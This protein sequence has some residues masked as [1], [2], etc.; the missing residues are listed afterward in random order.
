MYTHAS[1]SC[2]LQCLNCLHSCDN[3]R[4]WSRQII[5]AEVKALKWSHIWPTVRDCARNGIIFKVSIYKSKIWVI[6]VYNWD[7]I[8]ITCLSSWLICSTHQEEVQTRNWHQSF[9]RKSISIS[10]FSVS[11]WTYIDCKLANWVKVDGIGP[12]ILLKLKSLY[13]IWIRL[14]FPIEYLIVCTCFEDQVFYQTHRVIVHWDCCER[15]LW[16]K[17]K[18]Y[19]K[20][21]E[22]E[23]IVLHL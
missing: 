14:C 12:E 7:W 8:Y 15:D 22:R 13:K 18:G 6:S 10:S 4:E 23:K 1:Y 5:I 17:K 3:I 20:F 19:F 16:R 11:I 2:F 9:Y 21:E